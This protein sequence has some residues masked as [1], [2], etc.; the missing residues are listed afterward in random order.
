ML[1]SRDYVPR[2][3]IVEEFRDRLRQMG[4]DICLSAIN[5]VRRDGHDEEGCNWWLQTTDMSA[6]VQLVE[7]VNRISRYVRAKYNIDPLLDDC[8]QLLDET[9]RNMQVPLIGSAVRRRYQNVIVTLKNPLDSHAQCEIH[10]SKELVKGFTLGR[11]AGNVQQVKTTIAACEQ[12]IRAAML[13][14]SKV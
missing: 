7:T 5:L 9:V 11:Q 2:H 13:V 8:Q 3:I 1:F 12:A 10:V 14:P 6:N 4:S